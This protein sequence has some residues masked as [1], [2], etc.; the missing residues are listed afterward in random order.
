VD[1][2]Y[3][4]LPLLPGITRVKD[5]IDIYEE[6]ETIYEKLNKSEAIIA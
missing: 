3:N 2:S 5:W 1:C 4:R 6:I